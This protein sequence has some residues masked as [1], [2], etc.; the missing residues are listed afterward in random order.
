MHCA[1]NAGSRNS[2]FLTLMTASVE[3]GRSAHLSTSA[4]YADW[5]A[6]VE[7]ELK[8]VPFEKRFVT[9]TPEGIDVQPL[10]RREDAAALK[11]TAALGE[12]PYLRGTRRPGTRAWRWEAWTGS[13]EHDFSPLPALAVALAGPKTDSS[14]GGSLVAD[15][16]GWLLSH[17]SL[18][19][20]LACC[21][22][23]LVDGMKEAAKAGTFTRIAG[24]G[25]HIW[26]EC[27]ATAVQELA[28]ALA[29]GAEY[30]RW[31]LNCEITPG[32]IAARTQLSFAVGVDFFMEIAK[33]RAARVLWAKMT[34]A[35]GADAGAQ[36][37]FIAARTAAWD[38]TLYD[39]H[40]NLLRIITQALSAVVGGADAIDIRPYDE[41][42]GAPTELGA[43]LSRNLHAILAEEFSFEN[44][45]DPA[46]GAWYVEV[47]TEQLARKAWTLFQ[48]VGK[49]G[50]MAKAVLAGYPQSLV[51][52]AAEDKQALVNTRRRPILGTTAQPNLREEP[53]S[54]SPAVAP[55]VARRKSVPKSIKSFS[56]LLAAAAK[57]TTLPTLR[58]AWTQ[59][60]D[61]GPTA[62]ALKPFRAAEGFEAVRRA[63]D[64][65]LTRSGRRAQ[66]FLAKMGPAKQHKA[67]AD[68]ASG[69]FAIA[70]FELDDRKSFAT[71][72]EAADAA[73]ASG[74]AIAVLCST[75]DTYPQ[76]APVFAQR[77]KA[78]R[79]ALIVV[80]AGHP[81]EQEKEF[82]TT[83]FDEFIHLRSN[84][85]A[86]LTQLQ[87]L[88]GV[89][90]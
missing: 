32:E 60:R 84:V 65:F 38:K 9:R 45:I 40:V 64:D 20:S 80:L 34:G 10:Y 27:G 26:H 5:R 55:A 43:R 30:W 14:A 73:V 68:F 57:R 82:R 15:P 78:A 12:P 81:G 89:L 90:S 4:T 61:S 2:R 49:R 53:R 29:T 6:T 52:R 19:M 54:A 47:L 35:F 83:G 22:D 17:G 18:P 39:P 37:V 46:G 85:R 56:A 51:A 36:K 74:A 67:R 11:L 75:D 79:P 87:R 1:E 42:T 88:A 59:K 31:L 48:E 25:A 62:A 71:A 70:G 8:G 16:L 44:Q 28:F 77:I 58:I 13:S 23:D 33:L 63:G 41:V 76:L 66:V 21:F 7:Q 72:E 50:G 3:F 24:V 86:T 69:F